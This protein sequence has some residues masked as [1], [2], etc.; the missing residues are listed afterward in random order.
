MTKNDSGKK[1]NNDVINNEIAQE[2]C[3][4]LNTWTDSPD[5]K[6]TVKKT[7]CLGNTAGC[8]NNLANYLEIQRDFVHDKID[9]LDDKLN[10]LD[11]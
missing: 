9:C 2:R 1:V 6:L 10:N 3:I 8:L 4:R 5:A 11:N 7:D